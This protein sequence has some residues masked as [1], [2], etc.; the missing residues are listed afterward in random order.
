MGQR[1]KTSSD[2]PVIRSG[3][4][5]N[6]G[7]P[8]NMKTVPGSMYPAKDFHPDSDPTSPKMFF[9]PGITPICGIFSCQE[10]FL[11]RGTPSLSTFFP[12]VLWPAEN[13]QFNPAGQTPRA[14]AART[15]WPNGPILNRGVENFIWG[16]SASCVSKEAANL[17]HPS[18]SIS[19]LKAK[20]IGFCEFLSKTAIG[21]HPFTLDLCAFSLKDKAPKRKMVGHKPSRT[22][23]CLQHRT[24][25]C[26]IRELSLH[27]SFTVMMFGTPAR[28]CL[29]VFMPKK[30]Q[31]Q[32]MFV[33]ACTSC[34]TDV[35]VKIL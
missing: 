33:H 31:I 2:I 14:C 26:D 24:L 27:E 1:T 8:S 34:T 3:N 23:S 28:R 7:Q 12:S 16:R 19:T 6:Q 10:Q 25:F 17:W 11:E 13:L 22:K 9:S 21:F 5:A 20:P 30:W 15:Q 32:E 18:S 4:D 35:C 29:H